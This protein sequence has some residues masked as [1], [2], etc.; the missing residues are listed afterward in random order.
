MDRM[1]E[2]HPAPE[3]HAKIGDGAESG[4]EV[5]PDLEKLRAYTRTKLALAEQLRAARAALAALGREEGERYCRELVA[6]LA[7]D[8]FVL[9]VLGQFKRGKSSLMNAI[10]GR[11]LLPTGVLPLT[12]A[13]TVLKY[14]PLERLVV[15]RDGLIFPDELP[16]AALPD[17]VTEGGN[18]ANRKQVKTACVELP[19]PFL[20]RGIEFVDTP[21]VGSA[22]AAN[23]A[24][25][26]GF[27]PECDAVLFVTGVDTPLTSL[28][29]EFLKDIRE[30]AAKIF[31]VV[32]KVDLVADD[33]RDE[34]L[35]FVAETIRSRT[36]YDTVRLFPVSARLGLAA[37]LSGDAAGYERSGIK[38]LEEALAAF[39]AAEK[40]AVFL[41]GVARRAA[42]VLADEAAHGAFAAETLQVRAAV[43][44]SEGFVGLRC[45]PHAAAA[46]A[47][48]AQAKLEA[49]SESILSGRM[50]EAAAIAV[51]PAVPAQNEPSK[52]T[53]AAVPAVPA[54]DIAADLRIRGCPVCRH[55]T[56]SAA[57]FF[58]H[59][60]YQ[61]G[62]A[63]RAQ[64]EFAA[65]LG[66]CPLHT[67][68]L[69][70]LCSP[71]GASVGFARL[72]ETVARR[73]KESAALAA[74]G[75]AARRLVRDSRNCRVCAMLQRAEAEYIR[76]LAALLGDAA[77]RSRYY[78][79]Q[80]VCLRHL[81]MLMDT[82]ATVEERRF[83]LSHAAQRF[84]EDA[85]D[86]QSFALKHEALRRELEN[87][88]EEDAYRRAVIRMVGGK[89]VWLPWPEDVEI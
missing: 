16:V 12:S 69:L 47:L 50:A 76:R 84:E 56:Q 39:L 75:D 87:R 54:P 73:L 49:L 68:Q 81:G 44:Q 42:R 43:M 17:Y 37:R 4:A 77:G 34:I 26:Y 80:G 35:Q 72:A 88:N 30:Y 41:A 15:Q 89:N 70:A 7:E 33:E 25:T 66:F 64:D 40:S 8:R 10:I 48:E 29:L 52:A 23:T 58:A 28:E 6:K 19:V 20:R 9:A 38:A 1:N 21:G 67:W 32:N 61:I 27:L 24:L 86:M 63:E 65:E 78:R 60:Q 57:D 18:P 31:F 59:W 82:V 13:I 36:G 46:A 2:D 85:E 62:A 5:R 11:Q 74:A 45:D 71:H 79:S 51:Q 14:G 55:L 3:T 83:L 53:A 22:I